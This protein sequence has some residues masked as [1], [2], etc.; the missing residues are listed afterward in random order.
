MSD[1]LPQCIWTKNFIEAQGCDVG[2][3]TIY[4]DNQSAIKLEINGRGS[5]GKKT[6]HIDIRYFFI[7]DVAAQGKAR[8][9]YCP[10]DEMLADFFTKPLQGSKFLKFR[11]TILNVQGS[12][13]N[14]N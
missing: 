10:T 8:V 14:M 3:A 7:A 13:Y 5:S 9:E 1:V 12:P 6:R 2:P 4:Q 11:D